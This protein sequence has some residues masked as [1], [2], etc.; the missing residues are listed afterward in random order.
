MAKKDKMF[1]KS[2]IFYVAPTLFFFSLFAA[3]FVVVVLAQWQIGGLMICIALLSLYAL[4]FTAL[5]RKKVLA[6]WLEEYFPWLIG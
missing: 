5:P 2:V 4:K 1:L 3:L 6:A